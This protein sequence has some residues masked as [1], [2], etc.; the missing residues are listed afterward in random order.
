MLF[1][2]PKNQL[3]KTKHKNFL[4]TYNGKELKRSKENKFVK[5]G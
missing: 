5:S 4:S 2:G 3:Y 1:P